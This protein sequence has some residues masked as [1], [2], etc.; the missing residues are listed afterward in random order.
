M[1]NVFFYLLLITLS[2][3][4]NDKDYEF[5]YDTIITDT[6][7][8]L[9]KINSNYDDYNSTLPYPGRRQGIYFSTNRKRNGENFDII[10]ENLDISYH[11]KDD[12]LNI[13]YANDNSRYRSKLLPIIN[14]NY[15]EF[16]P[17]YFW[18]PTEYEYFF[19]ANNSD[20][21]YDI[22]YVYSLKSASGT[23]A[24][25]EI[26][27]GPENLSIVNSQ[28][29]DLYPT[30]DKDNTKLFFCSNRE[31]DIFNIYSLNL[32][33]EVVL[34]D[35]FNE[36][37]TSVSIIKNNILS[38]NLNDKCPYIDNNLL[39]FTSD[40]TGGFGG[41]DLY[42]SQLVN[43]EWSE[44]I[45]FGA[46][47]NSEYDE[48]RPITFSFLVFEHLMIFSSNRPEGKGGFDLYMVKTE[49]IIK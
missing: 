13:S 22:K 26:I 46:D 21:K 44:P 20:G 14:T 8:N 17:L 41:F 9:E 42:Y 7:V 35:Y 34:L 19:Y 31:E 28:F 2:S 11:E 15:D 27:N 37:T 10:Y 18:G 40:R 16:G 32:P 29:D 24:G 38:S 23:S 4:W 25:K 39:V 48:Y 43:G 30:I 47:I 6:P 49:N 1:R 5:E 33:T 3:C 12:V 36:N 45:N